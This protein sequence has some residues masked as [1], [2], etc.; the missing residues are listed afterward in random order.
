[1]SIGFLLPD[2]NAAVV[3]RGPRK[4]SMIDQFLTKVCWGDLD[5]LIIDTPPGTSDEHITIIEKIREY[6]LDRLRGAIVVTTPQVSCSFC[7]DVNHN[8]RRISFS[9][10]VSH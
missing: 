1:M 6:A 3:W 9:K 7:G 5:V 4:N 2:K 10:V 8:S